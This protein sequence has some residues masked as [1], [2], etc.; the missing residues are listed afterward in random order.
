MVN[1]HDEMVRLLDL[2]VQQQKEIEALRKL[3]HRVARNPEN[4]PYDTWLRDDI[5]EWRERNS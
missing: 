5:R 1:A 3:L 2:S 4:I